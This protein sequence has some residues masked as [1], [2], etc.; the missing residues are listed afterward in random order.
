MRMK[1]FWKEHSDVRIG[2][3]LLRWY[4]RPSLCIQKGNEIKKYGIF[5]SKEAANE[6]LDE[7]ADFF[8]V[9]KEVE[10]E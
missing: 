9:Q 3:Y 8:E 2:A 4:K 10:N 5:S 7:L 6:F 1:T